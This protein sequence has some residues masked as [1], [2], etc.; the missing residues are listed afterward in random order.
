MRRGLR[1]EARETSYL[2]SQVEEAGDSKRERATGQ[3]RRKISRVWCNGIHDRSVP[4]RSGWSA[5]LN[6]AEKSCKVRTKSVG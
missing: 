2:G 4:R 1:I 6:V 5:M 3:D